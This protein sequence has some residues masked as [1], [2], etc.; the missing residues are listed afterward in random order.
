VSASASAVG[1]GG[2]SAV[3]VV[4]VASSG[5]GLELR[6]GGGRSQFMVPCICIGQPSALPYPYTVGW[7]VEV[8]YAGGM[9]YGTWYTPTTRPRHPPHAPVRYVEC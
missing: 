3:V 2:W 9:V 1:S 4:G 6:G 8:W 7:C 5:A